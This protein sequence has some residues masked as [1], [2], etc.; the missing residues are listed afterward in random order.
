MDWGVQ[1]WDWVPEDQGLKLGSCDCARRSLG[2][3]GQVMMPGSSAWRGNE[4]GLVSGGKER[5]ATKQGGGT[6]LQRDVQVCLFLINPIVSVYV[7]FRKVDDTICP[8]R[9]S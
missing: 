6:L 5:W 7:C 3:K 1:E 9:I 8:R 2:A 4:G